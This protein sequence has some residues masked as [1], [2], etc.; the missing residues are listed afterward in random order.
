MEVLHSYNFC[1]LSS[2]NYARLISNYSH[3]TFLLLVLIG[4]FLF[5]EFDFRNHQKHGLI[6]HSEEAIA[7]KPDRFYQ[8]KMKPQT[9]HNVTSC[10]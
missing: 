1:L 10:A 8:P 9:V 7:L 5:V 2:E 6:M 3:Q 4:H